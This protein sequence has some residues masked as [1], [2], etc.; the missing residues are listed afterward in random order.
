MMEG[1]I[2]PHLIGRIMLSTKCPFLI[3]VTWEYI[4]LHGQKG[5]IDVNELMNLEEEGLLNEDIIGKSSINHKNLLACRD[6]CS[7][8]RCLQWK[9]GPFWWCMI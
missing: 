4:S 3:L 8:S 7:R 9:L 6:E 2:D 5:F 1:T